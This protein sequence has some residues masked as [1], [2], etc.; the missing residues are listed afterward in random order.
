MKSKIVTMAL[1]G[2]VL[3]SILS[4]S[5]AHA[6]NQVRSD[7]QAAEVVQELVEKG[8]LQIDPASGRILIKRSVYEI[9][10]HYQQTEPQVLQINDDFGIK[11]TGKCAS[12]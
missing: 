7:D 9:L 3:T 6:Q 10:R 12:I 1:V 5:M 8:Y 2:T 4:G 11:T